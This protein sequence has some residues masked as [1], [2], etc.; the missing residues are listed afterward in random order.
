[1]RPGERR[2]ALERGGQHIN[3]G[4]WLPSDI[5]SA[6]IEIGG[7]GRTYLG[8]KEDLTCVR[9]KNHPRH[10]GTYMSRNPNKIPNLLAGT[11]GIVGIMSQEVHL[12]P[13]VKPKKRANIYSDT[14]KGSERNLLYGVVIH[15]IKKVAYIFQAKEP[16]VARSTRAIKNL[17]A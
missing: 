12:L 17:I 4:R 7:S 5:L 1:M 11:R 15:M 6:K 13:E 8:T 2:T 16:R 10:N 9:G 14:S 3:L